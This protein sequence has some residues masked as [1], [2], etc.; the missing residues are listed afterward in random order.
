LRD[1]LVMPIYE[2]T[3][4]IQALM[5]MK[6][7]L[8]GIIK[9]PQSFVRRQA[10]SRW[11]VVAKNGLDRRVTKLQIQS[12][13][14]QQYLLARTA[15]DKAKTLRDK[16]LAE[17]GTE[18]T[19]NWDPKRDFAY[20]MLHAERLIRLLINEAIAEV[21]LSQ[22]KRWPERRDI[23]ERFLDRAEVQSRHLADEITTTGSRFLERLSEKRGDEAAKKAS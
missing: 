18:F 20:A 16:P 1:A 12:M 15:G 19:K 7:T 14:V 5:A 4:Q 10:Q 11:R 21:L 9:D 23:L 8:I 3:S 13:N 6:D 22:A 17:W 2:G